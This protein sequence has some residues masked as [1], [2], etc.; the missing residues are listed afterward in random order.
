V[1][2]IFYGPV[3]GEVPWSVGGIA[4]VRCLP[5]LHRM[6]ECEST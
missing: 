4:C 3:G 1:W 2:V 6:G 5:Q